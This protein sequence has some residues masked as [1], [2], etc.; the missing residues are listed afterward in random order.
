VDKLVHD[1]YRAVAREAGIPLIGIG[2]VLTWDDAAEFILAGATAIEMGT[3]LF[4]DPRSPERVAS[5]LA[6]WTTDQ[7]RKNIRELI[8]AVQ[9]A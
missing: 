5:G 1:V 8:G 3:A 9:P 6:Q 2:G 7:G 4:V